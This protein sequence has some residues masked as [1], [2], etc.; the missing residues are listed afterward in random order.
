[1]HECSC[2]APGSRHALYVP[3]LS[4]TTPGHAGGGGAAEG[5]GRQGCGTR[6]PCAAPRV[7]VRLWAVGAG[8]EELRQGG[9]HK[10]VI[11]QEARVRRGEGTCTCRA[12]LARHSS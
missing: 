2:A 3:R 9:Q 6:G 7:Q 4:P 5:G 12:R 1:M 10:V 8:G 11:Q